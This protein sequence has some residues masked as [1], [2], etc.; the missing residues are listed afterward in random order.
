[1]INNLTCFLER[2]SNSTHISH[3]NGIM[4][5]NTRLFA[6]LTALTTLTMA[7]SPTIANNN[8]PR[9][10]PQVPTDPRP[11]PPEQ[12]DPRPKVV[13]LGDSFSSGTGI[14]AEDSSYDEQGGGYSYGY[15]LTPRADR[16]CWRE[17][18]DTPGPRRAA[19]TG[20]LSIF[21]ACKGAEVY[22]VRQQ[23]DLLN[24]QW[25]SDARSGW[26]GAVIL[27]TAGGN[28]I[29]TKRGEDWPDLLQRC[30]LGYVGFSSCHNDDDNQVS[31]WPSIRTR[32]VG[33]Y[34]ELAVSA[35]QAKIRVMGYPRLMR[36]PSSGSCPRVSGINHGEAVWI[37]QQVDMLNQQIISAIN[38]VRATRPNVDLQF[39]DVSNFFS[40]GACTTSPST[41]HIN[42]RVVANSGSF[43]LLTSNAS[44][45][46][47]RRGYNDYYQALLN[48]L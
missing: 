9:P 44:F 38:D 24:A 43:P 39:V 15:T 23:L 37:D 20:A 19:A 6:A 22:H 2:D 10:R 47:T 25:K 34:Q 46:P 36:P 28:D 12:S 30:V 8:D 21:L 31:N 40:V 16:E 1:L 3:F 4:R 13:T 41:R 5:F 32:L 7:V 17:K 45:H 48:S 14:W 26:Q 27:L 42:D 33:L 11:V 18:E 29:R 35:P